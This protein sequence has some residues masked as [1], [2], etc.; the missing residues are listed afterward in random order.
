MQNKE[1]GFSTKTIH[2]GSI[3]DVQFGSLMMPIYQ[4]ATFCFDSCE[5]GGKRFEGTESGYVYSRAGNPTTNLLEE[6]IALLENAEAAVAFSSGMGA[7]SSVLWTVGAQGRHI[8]ADSTLY[9]CTFSLLAHGLT[10]YGVEVTFVDLSDPS[11]LQAELRENTIAVFFETP[12]NP[13]LKV[14]DIAAVAELAHEHNKDILVV[15]DSTFATPYLTRP[16]DLGADVV[17]HSATKYLNG[18]GDVI[19]GIA[20]GKTEFMTE[21][22]QF[23]R[24][25]ATGAVLGPHEAFLI[26]RGLKTLELRME[27]HCSN[28]LVLAEYLGRHPKVERVYFPGL[29]EHPNHEV[30][31]KQMLMF[32]GMIAFEVHGGREAGAKLLNNLQLCALA[33][34]LGDAETLVEHPATMTHS[35]YTAEELKEAGIA[36]GL[37]RISAGLE[38]I[39]DIVADF[40]QAFAKL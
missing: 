26:M 17:V 22:R 16:L 20:C 34:S 39:Q 31:R 3:R 40:E 30:A 23:G 10:R 2:G 33:V 36:E 8:I 35:V 37:V 38:T 24:R 32:G 25:S 7:I 5:Q 15:V 28:A 12:A 1:S 13:N 9:G 19:A 6:R 27:R 11:L 4:N 14:V 18:H 29:T 21:V